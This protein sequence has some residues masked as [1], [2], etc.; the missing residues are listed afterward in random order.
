MF[1][2]KLDPASFF[3]G[4]F[5]NWFISNVTQ[6]STIISYWNTLFVVALDAIWHKRNKLV[7]QGVEEMNRSVANEFKARTLKIVSKWCLGLRIWLLALTK[8][9]S[10][11]FVM[12]FCLTMVKLLVDGYS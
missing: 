12:A 9:G 4:I 1:P 3:A 11:K 6:K 8:M 10:S 5:D 7:F 2:S